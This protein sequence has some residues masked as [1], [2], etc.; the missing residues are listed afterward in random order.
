MSF[1]YFLHLFACLNVKFSFPFNQFADNKFSEVRFA[2]IVER[3]INRNS[4]L[5]YFSSVLVCVIALPY[6]GV[7]GLTFVFEIY[8]EYGSNLYLLLI[9]VKMYPQCTFG[10]GY[11]TA[12]FDPSL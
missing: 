5:S 1:I 10:W 9:F 7:S 8:I 11:V 4:L 12:S 6:S 3:L 2:T